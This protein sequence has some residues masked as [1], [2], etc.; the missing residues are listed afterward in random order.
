MPHI[1]IFN[2]DAFSVASLTKAINEQPFQ[3]MRIGRL[4]LFS[5]E[6]ITT[7][8]ATVEKQGTTL[9]LVPA[10]ARNSPGTPIGNDK[11]SLI[12]IN[13]VHLPQ[14]GAVMADEVQN[15]RAFGTETELESVQTLTNRKLAKM[16][17]N[18]D[19][20]IEYQRIGAIKGQVVDSD[21]TTVLLDLL[22]TFGVSQQTHAMLLSNDATKV[23]I[24]CV[25]AA[26]KV[27]DALG[28]LMYSGLHAFCSATFFDALV[29]HPAVEKAYDRWLDGAFLRELQRNQEGGVGFSFGGITWEEYRGVVSGI[30]FIEANTAYLVPLGVQDLFVTH[31]APANYMETV[32]TNGLP[33]YAKQEMMRMNKGVELEA[34]SNPISMCTR[35][36]VVV[37]LTIS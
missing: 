29:G 26:R 19:V 35:P 1:D 13:T 20:T 15:M 37:K 32:N 6:G 4:G 8:A 36:N 34:Q 33:Y 30:P 25:E 28:G 17:R 7:T 18:L 24:K 12:P 3:P 31:Y 21:G 10:A 9:T 23:K 27:E 22:T 2:D 14:S 5:E 11:R 16:R